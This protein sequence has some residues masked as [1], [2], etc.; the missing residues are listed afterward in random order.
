MGT[1]CTTNQ[2]VFTDPALIPGDIVR[3]YHINELRT[4]INREYVRRSK[5]D[6]N[7]GV[8]KYVGD[9]I[10]RDE[11]LFVVDKVNALLNYSWSSGVRTDPLIE[12]EHVRELQTNVNI[13]ETKCLCHCDYCACQCNYCTCD[14]NYCTCDC[15]HSCTCNCNYTTYTCTCDCN[16]ACTCNC[17]CNGDAGPYCT[18]DCNH[19]TCD[20]NHCTCNCNHC[21]CH[22]NHACTCDCNY[23]CSCD[24]N[25]CTCNCNHSCTCN[26][27]YSDIR[28]KTEITYF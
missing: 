27:N 24:C 1:P 8:V 19:C 13:E 10:K 26:C 7:L 6:A 9:V 28:L 11:F 14:C 3:E 2:T 22:C 17:N 21:T 25:Y 16:H 15:N 20:C 23:V 5:P 18:C 12:A 4:A